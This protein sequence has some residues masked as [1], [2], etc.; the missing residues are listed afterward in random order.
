[1]NKPKPKKPPSF[2]PICD[3]E[4]AARDHIARHFGEELNDIIMEFEDP[5]QCSQCPYKS[6]KQKNVAIHVAL[7]HHVLD[8]F[9]DNKELVA[10]R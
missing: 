3:M 1:M 10:A 9:L 7:T 8:R 4:N 2:C 6:D 5:N